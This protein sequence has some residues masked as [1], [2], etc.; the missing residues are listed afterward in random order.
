MSRASEF[1]SADSSASLLRAILDGLPNAIIF[2]LDREYRYLAFNRKH[3]SAMRD[4]WNATVKIGDSLLDCMTMPS[5]R[6]LA[7]ASIDRAL[8]GESFIERQEQ[9][10]TDILYE[11]RWQPLYDADDLIIGALSIAADLTELHSAQLKVERLNIDLE[12]R[13]IE[14]GALLAAANE[15][16]E[17]FAS[18]ITHDLKA[19]LRAISG[20]SAMV[21]EDYGPKLDVEGQRKLTVIA[22]NAVKMNALIC[23]LV[24]LIRVGIAK[25]KPV[26]IAMR[27]MARAMYHESASPEDSS[28]I[29]FDLGDIPDCVGDPTLLRK[30]WAN[31]FSNA[32]K[33]TTGRP[34]R[35]IEVLADTSGTEIKYRIR[36]NGVG[37]DNRY[38][39]KLFKLFSRLHS[40]EAYAGAGAGLA[41]V[42]RIVELHGGK[43]GA[44]MLKGERTEFWFTLPR[45]EASGSELP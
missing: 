14:R 23:D 21:L 27:D 20:Y 8:A 37:F 11:L 5:L 6:V 43:V 22:D 31:L 44:E 1:F 45:T 12:R 9:T 34:G 28:A 42:K 24:A 33:F 17:S 16:L 26:P 18:N 19:P 10:G 41:I 35:V 40:G 36:D 4:V 29:A 32:I 39:H 30:V 7:K 3:R 2:A 38:A 15:E 13:G 25:L